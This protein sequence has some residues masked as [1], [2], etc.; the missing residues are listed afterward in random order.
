[1]IGVPDP[2]WGEKVE[3]FVVLQPGTSASEEELI[4]FCRS[5]LASYKKPAGI[6]FLPELPKNAVGKVL[7]FVLRQQAFQ[8]GPNK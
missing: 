8:G 6:K 2:Y 7:K 3:A 4:D 1:V 5:Q